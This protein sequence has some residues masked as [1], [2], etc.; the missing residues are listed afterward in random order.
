MKNIH[1]V[2]PFVYQGLHEELDFHRSVGLPDFRQQLGVRVYWSL[3]LLVWDDALGWCDGENLFFS[4]GQV[5][6]LVLLFSLGVGRFFVILVQRLISLSFIALLNF[7]DYNLSDATHASLIE[8]SLSMARAN[9][10]WYLID[11][12]PSW[13]QFEC[14]KEIWS[15]LL[16]FQLWL[17][18][19]HPKFLIIDL[20]GA[21]E[22]LKFPFVGMCPYWLLLYLAWI[23]LLQRAIGS[24]RYLKSYFERS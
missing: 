4:K 24:M 22:E 23:S 17:S 14:Q 11:R 18:L 1:V 16:I 2:D 7:I 8:M 21:L 20:Q 10:L 19:N 15:L 6:F 5:G 9:N 13:L 3:T 12:D